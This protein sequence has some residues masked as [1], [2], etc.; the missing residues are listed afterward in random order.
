[1]CEPTCIN[2]EKTYGDRYRIGHDEVA[3]TWGERRD[4]WMMTIPCVGRGITIYPHGGTLL[5]LECDRRP[6]IAR[7]LAALLGVRVHQD[8]GMGGEM[9]FLFD[10]SLFEHIAAIVKPRRRRRLSD[11]QRARLLVAGAEALSRY[12]ENANAG[13]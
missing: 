8:G 7:Q 4:P 10:V 9:T 5:A 12:R 6:G 2:L 3:V 13:A 11:E 1:M